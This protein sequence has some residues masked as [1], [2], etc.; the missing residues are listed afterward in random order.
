M[1]Y[2]RIVPLL[3]TLLAL[4]PVTSAQ[5]G[6]ARHPGHR[7][8]RLGK[9]ADRLGL[10]DAQREQAKALAR[11]HKDEI[12]GLHTSVQAAREELQRVLQATPQD[13]DAVRAASRSVAAAEENLAV[14]RGAR[15]ADLRS[16]LTPEQQAKAQA[17]QQE[18]AQKRA[19]REQRRAE[20]KA[21]R[22][23]KRD[24]DGKPRKA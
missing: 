11:Q 14:A 9:A 13:A 4:A 23:S 20:H 21:Q 17:H 16:V 2:T 19:G 18:R 24:A 6:H 12:H 8:H 3:F 22:Q 10:T 15:R 7:H 1:T 5:D